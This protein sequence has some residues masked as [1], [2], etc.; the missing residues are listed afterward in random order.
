[1]IFKKMNIDA[2]DVEMTKKY[3]PMLTEMR[4]RKINERTDPGDRATAF[5]SEILARQCLSELLDAP[6]FSFQLMCNANFKSVVGNYGAYLYIA[7]FGST[8]ACA[9]SLSPVGAC[10]LPVRPFSFTEA[11]KLFSD[12][13]VRAIYSGSGYSFAELVNKPL[14]SE[15]P[16]MK[17]FAL[18]ASLKE[19]YFRATGR[20]Y[21]ANI[22]KME[23]IY[24]GTD[25]ECSDPA[26][27][28]A[29]CRVDKEENLAISVV[30]KIP[31]EKGEPQ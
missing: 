29:Y 15:P 31:A 5:C 16:V 1:M 22:N 6:E 12:S 26:Y 18:Y 13:E 3:Y 23:F 4:R 17:M 14:C 27:R 8:V 11:Q 10:I 30:E 25:I 20:G 7:A 21:R 24:N 9:A 2:L 19:S 28:V